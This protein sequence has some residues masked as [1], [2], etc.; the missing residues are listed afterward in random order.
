LIWLCIKDELIG[1]AFFLKQLRCSGL[2]SPRR[3]QR[4]RRLM[5]FALDNDALRRVVAVAIRRG[6]RVRRGYKKQRSCEKNL[7][8][9][10]KTT[11]LLAVTNLVFQINFA[12]LSRIA[13][14]RNWQFSSWVAILAWRQ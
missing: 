6:R 9:E 13:A 1:A 11:P 7:G 10:N 14:S 4:P 5:R 12:R 2:I 3:T 8:L